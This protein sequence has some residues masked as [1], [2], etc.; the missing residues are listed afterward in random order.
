[1]F[2]PITTDCTVTR[3]QAPDQGLLCK[4]KVSPCCSLLTLT[5]LAAPFAVPLAALS[6]TLVPPLEIRII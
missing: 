2:S 5:T 3:H 6:L 4:V 1:M